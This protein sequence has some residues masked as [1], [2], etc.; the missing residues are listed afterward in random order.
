MSAMTAAAAAACALASIG[1]DTSSP[2]GEAGPWDD[3]PVLHGLLFSEADEEEEEDEVSLIVIPSC[4]LLAWR[5]NKMSRF[6]NI[7]KVKKQQNIKCLGRGN[8]ILD[9]IPVNSCGFRGS[10]HRTGLWPTRR[11]QKLPSDS[12]EYNRS[13]SSSRDYLLPLSLLF[14]FHQDFVLPCKEA[15]AL[16]RQPRVDHRDKSARA[17]YCLD[18]FRHRDHKNRTLKNK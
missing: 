5:N 9:R 18:T 10:L 14:H 12:P 11:L 6:V 8:K 7:L 15:S 4:E 1:A 2:W 16:G 3:G 17:S 13:Q